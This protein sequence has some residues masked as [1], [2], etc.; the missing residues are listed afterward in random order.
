MPM[1]AV[2][3]TSWPEISNGWP[4]ASWM[5]LA[6]SWASTGSFT[7]SSRMVN[8]SPPWRA[9]VSPSRRQSWSRRAIC[10][11]SSS[12]AAWPSPSFT[13]LKWSRSRKSTAKT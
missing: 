7:S 11:S 8:S 6:T 3:N 1:L 9:R 5:R 13:D 12:P 2:A 4:V 10:R